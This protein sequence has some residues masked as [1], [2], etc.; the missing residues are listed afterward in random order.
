MDALKIKKL[1]ARLLRLMRAGAGYYI[2]NT[3][4]RDQLSEWCGSIGLSEHIYDYQDDPS[5]SSKEMAILKASAK[6]T[7]SLMS[8]REA[9]EHLVIEDLHF[10]LDGGIVSLGS[11][12]DPVDHL[13]G[14][15]QRVVKGVSILEGHLQQV[16]SSDFEVEEEALIQN[17]LSYTSSVI[18]KEKK[19]RDLEISLTSL[20]NTKELSPRT[21]KT[22]DLIDGCKKLVL[23]YEEMV[24]IP[25]L[26][27]KNQAV[28]VSD[29]DI[30]TDAYY[31]LKDNRSISSMP[32]MS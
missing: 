26:L 28:L 3:A 24:E 29:S 22:I 4:S 7:Y 16:V 6:K 21:A 8:E 10:D 30:P 20:K 23:Q 5:L 32:S 19:G 13:L 17:L 25:L 2:K 9:L 18:G 27:S 14:M 15:R 1:Q 31:P 12:G 11:C